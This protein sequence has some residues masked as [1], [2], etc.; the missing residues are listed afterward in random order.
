MPEATP[1]N[2]ATSYNVHI[3]RD[4]QLHIDDERQLV[5]AGVDPS[6]VALQVLHIE[7]AGTGFAVLARVHDDRSGSTFDVQ[8]LPDGTTQAPGP[9]PTHVV[10]PPPAAAPTP[11]MPTPSLG[12]QVDTAQSAARAYDFTTAIPLADEIL[13]T[14]TTELGDTARE[15]LEVAQFRADLAFL[16]GNYTFAT[17]S[18]TWLALAWFDRLGPG[19][20]RTQHAA[21]SAA[22]AWTRLSPPEA[23]RTV[24]DVVGM[25]QEVTAPDRTQALRTQIEQRARELSTGWRP[26][27]ESLTS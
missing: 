4:G 23:A 21:Q 11:V 5:P 12:E 26:G 9:A 24:D 13:H 19:K 15:T 16:S 7:A 25:L 1:M 2:P 8:I 22:V 3:A 18:W 14:L 10:E 6:Q 17:A 20:W 27:P